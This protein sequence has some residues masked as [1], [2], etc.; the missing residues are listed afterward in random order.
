MSSEMI[1][2]ALIDATVNEWM[3]EVEHRQDMAAKQ[4][5]PVADGMED[6]KELPQSAHKGT[7]ALDGTPTRSGTRADHARIQTPSPTRPDPRA[8]M[9]RV[10]K[11]L[12][13]TSSGASVSFVPRSRRAAGTMDR[14]LVHALRQQLLTE[15]ELA[16]WMKA[17]DC[18]ESPTWRSVCTWA[19]E[20]AHAI[21]RLAATIYGFRPVLICQMSTLVLAD[22]LTLRIPEHLWRP[23]ME[24]GVIPVVEHGRAPD[25]S[26]RVVCVSNDP[27]NRRVRALLDE[28][29]AFSP[30]LAYADAHHIRTMMDLLAQHVPLIGS[31]VY[32]PR[33]ALKR[34]DASVDTG[35]AA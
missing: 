28:I 6:S 34:V 21:E 13:Q 2:F 33:P 16:H 22:L 12:R 8:A 18:S 11:A 7:P 30:E 25:P 5:P 27:T 14:V 20:R 10:Y 35:K 19:P 3:H 31:L 23:M 1:D 26:N 29:L 17:H 15:D 9:R 32:T 24:N 4:A